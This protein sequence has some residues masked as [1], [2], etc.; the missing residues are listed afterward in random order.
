MYCA[1]IQIRFSTVKMA[2]IVKDKNIQFVIERDIIKPLA[3]KLTQKFES[4]QIDASITTK[5]EWED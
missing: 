3:D 4:D 2:K 5:T 1:T